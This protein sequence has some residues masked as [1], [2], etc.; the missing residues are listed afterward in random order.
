MDCDFMGRKPTLFLCYYLSTQV[1]GIKYSQEGENEFY[2]KINNVLRPISLTKT[3]F[4][5]KTHVPID[6]LF[7]CTF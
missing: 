6:T 7:Y 1:V 2:L 3:F 4:L 5:I